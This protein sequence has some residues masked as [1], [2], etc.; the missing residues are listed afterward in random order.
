MVWQKGTSLSFGDDGL[1]DSG[2]IIRHLILPGNINDSKSLLKHLAYEI[3]TNLFISLLSQYSPVNS[4][5][6]NNQLQ[7]AI[8]PK[9]YDDVINAYQNLG[10]YRGW[11]Q[12]L[13]SSKDYLP[14]FSRI[15]VLIR[16]IERLTNLSL[17][18]LAS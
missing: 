7:R 4:K 11:L 17:A 8:T 16:A 6:C 3:S 13:S 2:V 1:A 14:N 18:V 9:E 10:F 12:D 15:I 5:N